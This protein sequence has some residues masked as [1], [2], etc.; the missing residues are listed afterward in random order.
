MANPEPTSATGRMEAARRHRSRAYAERNELIAVLARLYPSHLMPAGGALGTLNTRWVVCIHT[1][2]LL[3]WVIT[4]EEAE[5]Y[6]SSMTRI[7][8]NHWDKSTRVDR[9][10]RL[11]QLTALPPPM[12]TKPKKAKKAKKEPPRRPGDFSRKRTK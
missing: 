2:A 6:F 11:S 5:D 4:H 3:C 1:P 9:S 10:E 12:P 7:T 8:E